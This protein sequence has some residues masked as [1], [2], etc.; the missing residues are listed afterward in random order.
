MKK[1]LAVLLILGLVVGTLAGCAQEE[2]AAPVE[3]PTSEEATEAP[4]ETA[5]AEPTEL[6]IS[7]W[8]YNEDL[9]RKNVFDAFEAQN[10]VK[11]I[12]EVGNNSDRLNK[13][14][15]MEDS[16]VD[17]IFLAESFAVQGIEEDLF[18]SFDRSQVPNIEQIYEVCQAPHGESYG[19]SYTVNRTGIIYD[20]AMVDFEVTSWSDL[21]N[22]AFESNLAIPEITT[23]AGPA[24]V[25]LAGQKV[26]ADALENADAAFAELVALKPN[27]MKIYT[28]SS[29]M[30]NMFAQGEIIGAVAND[31]AFGRVLDAVPTAAWIDP[32]EGGFVNRNTVNLVKGTENAEMA[33]K[34]INYW[35][36]EEVQKACALDK[37]DSPVNANV[38]LTEEESYGLTY[39]AE[40]MESL[41]AI[42]STEVNGVKAEWINRWNRE[43]AN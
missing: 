10:N 26:E 19:P 30:V 7:T 31:F 35:L 41:Q 17:V 18:E 23:T 34:L 13:I 16:N 37:I 14:R 11:I 2:A 38:V 32:V 33:Y 22:P 21:W 1:F 28:R 25:V 6:I 24:M 5:S 3:A 42:D 39:G 12:L 40:L 29:E 43:V 15:A 4:A 9:F 20:T 27:V 8:G 36:S